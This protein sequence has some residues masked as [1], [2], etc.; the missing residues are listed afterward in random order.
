MKIIIAN[1]YDELSKKAAN[2]IGKE[3][4]KNPNIVLGLAT[5]STPLGTYKE[6]IRLH[7]EEGLDFSQ[8]VTFNLDEYYGLSKDNNQSYFC[9]M[10][11]NFFKHININ[12]KNIHIPDGSVK[13]IEE[14]CKKYDD[15]I[16]SVGGIDLQLVGIGE[17]G[18]IGFNEP[19]D[20]LLLDTHLTN[21]TENTIEANSRFF[22]SIDKVP[23]K[24]ITMG[25]GSIMKAKKILLLAN[26][27]N[28]AKVMAQL[29]KG[30]T[31]TTKMPASAL[32]LHENVNIIIDEKVAYIYKRINSNLKEERFA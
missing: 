4:K 32:L 11:E 29:I 27:E 14:Y 30:E 24:A 2:I 9:Y 26:G 16:D 13:D 1:N 17:N 8:V 6:L 25:L 22:D 23:T 20:E 5:G 28:K 3:I 15:M 21:L 19:D 31:I 7:V 18:H 10:N 12:P